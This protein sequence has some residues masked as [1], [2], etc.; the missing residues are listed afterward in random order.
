MI[1]S[2]IDT[3][4]LPD[5]LLRLIPT[6]KVRIREIDGTVQLVPV[7][8]ITDCTIGL[9]GILADCDDMSVDKFLER[10]RVD[11]ELDL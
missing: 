6:E 2:V 1:E 8:E 9:R 5:I 7:K 3:K 11:K 10:M 4:S